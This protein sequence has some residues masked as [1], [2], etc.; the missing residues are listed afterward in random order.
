MDFTKKTR[1]YVKFPHIC[2]FSFVIL[3]D[4]VSR[5]HIIHVTLCKVIYI[6]TVSI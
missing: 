1:E 5:G 4:N 6:Y 3:K 2:E